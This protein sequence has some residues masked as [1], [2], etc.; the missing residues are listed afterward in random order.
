MAGGAGEGAAIPRHTPAAGGYLAASTQAGSCGRLGAKA[1][2]PPGIVPRPQLG[3]I[4][5]DSS[6]RE[7]RWGGSLCPVGVP[8][9]TEH[10]PAARETL[11][12]RS[13]QV[14]AVGAHRWALWAVET[15]WATASQSGAA[16]HRHGWQAPAACPSVC[17]TP[18]A[19]HAL[20]G[21]VLGRG[22]TEGTGTAQ[23]PGLPR[24]IHIPLATLSD[25]MDLP[26]NVS[27]GIADRAPLP[28]PPLLPVPRSRWVFPT[29]K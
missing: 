15:R 20:L 14:G 27:A 21:T 22:L 18:P 17:H 7:K 25:A 16:W 28:S 8:G 23:E 24:L 12:L 10:S 3:R 5:E 13:P 11:R 26:P 2:L 1:G 29:F 6:A 9:L 19:L 4:I